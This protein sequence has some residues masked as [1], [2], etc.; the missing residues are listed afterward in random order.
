MSSAYSIVGSETLHHFHSRTLELLK[1]WIFAYLESDAIY[2]HPGKSVNERMTLIRILTSSL[3]AVNLT[4]VP[5]ERY[6]SSPVLR[7]EVLQRVTS[8]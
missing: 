6:L 3:R 1:D 8:M 2:S 5:M 7:I 4:P